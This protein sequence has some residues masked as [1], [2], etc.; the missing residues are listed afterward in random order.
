MHLPSIIAFPLFHLIYR[1]GHRASPIPPIQRTIRKL[2]AAEQSAFD[3][4][5]TLVLKGGTNSLIDYRL[6]YP[7]I[8]FLNYLCD[9]LG[10]VAHGSINQDLNILEPIRLSNDS[11]EFGNRRQVFCSPDAIW[12]LWFAILDKSKIHVTENGC[13]RVGV[14]I[15]CIKY[16]QFDLPSEN[17][18]LPPFT[19][20]MIYIAEAHDFPDR[21]HIPY[22]DWFNAE[23]E[24]WGSATPVTPLAKLPVSPQDFPYLEWVQYRL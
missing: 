13:V 11:S 20:G 24:E 12:A 5:L 1:I 2:P 10:Y 23:Y 9:W 22:L 7:K 6:P 15:R 19:N 21:P 8:D 4:L 17:K 14:G 3:D 16:Y 18:D